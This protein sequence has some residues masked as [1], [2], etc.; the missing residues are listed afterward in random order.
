MI[1]LL[2]N[3]QTLSVVTYTIFCIA[4]NE[5]N[6]NCLKLGTE[7]NFAKYGP[8]DIDTLN[9]TYDYGSVMHY[10]ANAFTSNGLRTIIP[11]DPDAVI[12]QRVGMSALDILEVQRYYK[13]V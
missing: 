4:I 11:K 3:G 5:P 10:E 13:C 1:M 9:I 7:N 8:V 2:F 12:G 6:M